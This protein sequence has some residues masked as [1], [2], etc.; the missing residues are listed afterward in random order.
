MISRM[1][2]LSELDHWMNGLLDKW[3]RGTIRPPNNPPIHQSI[4]PMPRLR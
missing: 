4:N 2:G 3:I 1:K